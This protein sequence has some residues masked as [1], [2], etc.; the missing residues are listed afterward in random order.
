VA[1]GQASDCVLFCYIFPEALL[2][3]GQIIDFEMIYRQIAW[4]A[5]CNDIDDPV[6]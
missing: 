2:R 6:Q 3:T 5:H 4:M 1:N